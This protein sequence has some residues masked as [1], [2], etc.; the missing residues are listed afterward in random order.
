MTL[1]P[2]NGTGSGAIQYTVKP[3]P[4]AT[5][6]TATITVTPGQGG[7]AMTVT[8]TLAGGVLTIS[9]TSASVA[10]TGGSGTITVTTN[11][12]ALRWTVSADQ[13]WMT[14]TSGGQGTGPAQIQWTAAANTTNASRTSNISV[15]P[16]GGTAQL[17]TITQAP[18]VVTGTITLVP[19]SVIVP[20]S[21]SNGTILVTSTNQALTWTATS[22]DSW[23]TI[24]HG[25]TGTGK[26]HVPIQRDGQPNRGNA[27]GDHHRDACQRDGRHAYCQS[28]GG[29]TDHTSFH[30]NCGRRRR[31]G[32]FSLTTNSSTL[33]WSA[34]SNAAFLTITTATSGTGDTTMSW[35][36]A[37]NTT[38]TT[39]TATIA[40]TP[41]GG[42][43]LIF[44]VTQASLSGTITA[45]PS[46]LSFSY[47]QLGSVPAAAQITLNASAGGLPFTT[48][49]IGTW[50]S[51]MSNGGATPGV[52]TVSVNPSGLGVGTYQGA[53]LVT[54]AAATNS[55]L[56]I[57]VTL[58]VSA[59]PVLTAAPNALSFSYQQGGSLPG[60]QNLAI[61]AS[62]S[63]L[64]YTIMPDPTAPW[65]TA[66]GAGPAPATVTVSVS[67]T[68]LAPGTYQGNVILIAPAAGNSTFNI[69]VSLTVSATPNLI[70]APT[71]LSV[72]YRQLDPAP[73]PVQITVN[74]S[75]AALSFT[76]SVSPNTTWLGLS[77]ISRFSPAGHTPSTVQFTVDP[78]GLAPG[79][80]QGSILVTSDGAGTVR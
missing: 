42:P 13:S 55:P 21:I 4:L 28:I 41:Q 32:S 3:N 35:A 8:V 74:S 14:I 12:P 72:T 73:A 69:P 59:A 30:R 40:V 43:P 70:A 9:P 10:G 53:V 31:H 23:L 77:G 62:G 54:S 56:S 63:S 51:V 45:V 79:P 22:S 50:L 24:T 15:T 49:V 66:T 65:L 39:R 38:T 1:T 26:R 57:P 27:N 47:Q 2:S 46:A 29:G 16:S 48:S 61:G 67:T 20:A 7:A 19:G 76:P 64:D 68:G 33:Q 58:T 78:T 36:A 80:Y 34:A 18:E 75:G 37:A 52:L 17:S 71:S 6:R 25:A 44:R 11:N 60:S 5:A